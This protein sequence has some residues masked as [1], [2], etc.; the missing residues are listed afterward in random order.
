MPIVLV[1]YILSYFFLAFKK[2]ANLDEVHLIVF[3]L[4]GSLKDRRIHE[5][6]VD[7]DAVDVF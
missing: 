1:G 7:V 5:M 6:A 3:P 2:Q 4:A